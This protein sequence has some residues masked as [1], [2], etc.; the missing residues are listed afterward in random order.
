[1]ILYTCKTNSLLIT[2]KLLPILNL[3]LALNSFYLRLSDFGKINAPVFLKKILGQ[4]RRLSVVIKGVCVFVSLM[5]G[6]SSLAE[7]RSVKSLIEIRRQNVVVQQWDLSCGAAALT[8]LLNYQHNDFV[9]EKEV[10]NALM[11]RPEYIKTPD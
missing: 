10:A 4:S 7:A 8:T 2:Y 5:I 6:F 1:M 9:T 3:A 11:N